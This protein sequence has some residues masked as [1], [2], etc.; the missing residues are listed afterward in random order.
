MLKMR[1]LLC[2][3]KVKWSTCLKANRLQ[4]LYVWVLRCK[5]VPRK[6]AFTNMFMYKI[7]VYSQITKIFYKKV[8]I[9]LCISH[10]FCT[11]APD[12]NRKW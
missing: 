8:C 3:V 2:L 12:F 11:F 1:Y 6:S 4:W 10:F 7:Y 9:Y 5:I